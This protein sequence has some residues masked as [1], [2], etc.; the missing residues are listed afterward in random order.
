MENPEDYKQGPGLEAQLDYNDF[1]Q[2][3]P[4]IQENITELQGTFHDREMGVM[5]GM[6][7]PQKDTFNLDMQ[8]PASATKEEDV[9]VE[10]AYDWDK[11]EEQGAAG[12]DFAA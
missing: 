1:G 5:D 4:E 6:Q 12:G 11:E 2:E 8:G 10:S 7:I 3:D 9:P